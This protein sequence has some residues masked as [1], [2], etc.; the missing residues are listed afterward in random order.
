[1]LQPQSSAPATNHIFSIFLPKGVDYCNGYVPPYT[2]CFSPDSPSTWME[3]AEHDIDGFPDIP[4]FEYATLDPY[5]D[6]YSVV[7]GAPFYGCDVGRLPPYDTNTN[8]TPNGVLVDTVGS[9]LGHEI[10]E[11]ITDPDGTEW[12]AADGLFGITPLEY[13][14]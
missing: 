4:G 14:G 9:S 13:I 7:N 8:P 2:F 1:M 6:V 5:P 3:C 11:T 10:F 12:Q